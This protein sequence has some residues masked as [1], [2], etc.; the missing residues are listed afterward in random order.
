MVTTF[1][2][3]SLHQSFARSF[4][5]TEHRPDLPHFILVNDN[6][7][8]AA[9]FGVPSL[10][11]LGVQF[12]WGFG[13]SKDA[14]VHKDKQ[15]LYQEALFSFEAHFSLSVSLNCQSKKLWFLA[16]EI[17]CRRFMVSSNKLPVPKFLTRKLQWCQ[18]LWGIGKTTSGVNHQIHP[19]MVK[20]PWRVSLR[21]ATPV[22]EFCNRF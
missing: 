22:R 3:K 11:T 19:Q 7:T 5:T 13:I 6:L 4:Q 1:T 21:T 18:R 17:F 20:S 9:L 8:S 14:M 10:G 12:W 15:H 16:F 2:S